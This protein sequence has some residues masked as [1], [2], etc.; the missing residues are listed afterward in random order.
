MPL[1]GFG[2]WESSLYDRGDEREQLVTLTVTENQRRDAETGFHSRLLLFFFF[3]GGGEVHAAKVI[4]K[5]P[6]WHCFLKF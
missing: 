6:A 5:P 2:V 1:L 3:F 4:L